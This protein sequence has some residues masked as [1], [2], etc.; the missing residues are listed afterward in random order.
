[1]PWTA[2]VLVLFDGALWEASR[3]K[4]RHAAAPSA[5]VISPQTPAAT[6]AGPA[7]VAVSAPMPTAP[8]APIR[9]TLAP[10]A[11]PA[12]DVPAP[13]TLE[14]AQPTPR[15]SLAPRPG[16]ERTRVGDERPAVQTTASDR[17][18]LL[19][20]AQVDFDRGDLALALAL[21]RQAAHG[22]AGAPAYVLIGTIMMNEHRDD[23]AE[24]AFTEATLC[25][26][27]DPRAARLLAMVR[28]IRKMG[29][30]RP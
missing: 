6:P 11:T 22:G 17:Q 10:T 25:T 16:R 4:Y 24:R 5:P 9:P 26:P 20:E 12:T 30:E 28:E 21:A 29:A 7:G 2:A 3:I 27:K 14:P 15:K 19:A 13:S 18:K 1:L 23:E 8:A